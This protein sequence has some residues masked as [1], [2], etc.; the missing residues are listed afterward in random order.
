MCVCACARHFKSFAFN[1]ISIKLILLL[2]LRRL[3]ARGKHK[4]ATLVVSVYKNIHKQIQQ[5]YNIASTH[6]VT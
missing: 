6:L 4:I 3:Y 2:L 5:E 1:S